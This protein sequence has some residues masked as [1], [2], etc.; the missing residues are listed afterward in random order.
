MLTGFVGNIPRE[1]DESAVID[2]CSPL[3]IFTGIILPLMRPVIMTAIVLIFIGIWN[4]YMISL[5]FIPKTSM[6]TMPL[7]VQ[8]FIGFHT[9]DMQLICTHMVYTMVPVVALYLFAQKYIVSGLTS[10]SV[11][12]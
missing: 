10:G 9:A 1:L 2:G 3:R 4:D 12:G 11:K 5:Y 8:K 6:Y 7:M